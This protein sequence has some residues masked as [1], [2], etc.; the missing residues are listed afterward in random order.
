VDVHRKHGALRAF[1]LGGASLS[2]VGGRV[3]TLGRLAIG[4]RLLDGPWAGA[5]PSGQ[6]VRLRIIIHFFWDQS[7]SLLGGETIYFDRGE[8]ELD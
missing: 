4:G 3:W 6:P 7:T 1:R 2:V 8:L 5:P